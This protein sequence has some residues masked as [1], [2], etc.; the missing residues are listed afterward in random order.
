[1]TSDQTF[2]IFCEALNASPPV[3]N[4]LFPVDGAE[5]LGEFTFKEVFHDFTTGWTSISIFWQRVT[6]IVVSNHFHAGSAINKRAIA[7]SLDQ[8]MPKLIKPESTTKTW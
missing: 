1:M 3:L 5:A 8:P 4:I 7:R 6:I 2:P